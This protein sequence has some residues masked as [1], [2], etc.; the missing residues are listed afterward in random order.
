VE[1]VI[2]DGTLPSDAPLLAVLGDDCLS[3]GISLSALHGKAIQS[4]PA[5]PRRACMSD[6][7]SSLTVS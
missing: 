2:A 1:K 3:A 5:L 6:Y 4:A 7:G